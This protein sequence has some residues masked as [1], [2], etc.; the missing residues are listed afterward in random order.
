MIV[1]MCFNQFST[2]FILIEKYQ[3]YEEISDRLNFCG[4]QYEKN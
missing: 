3:K 2:S 4:N 1:S